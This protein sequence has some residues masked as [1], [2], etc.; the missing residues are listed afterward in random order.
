MLQNY[1]IARQVSLQ[2][3]YR[4]PR[5][6]E[7]A[8]KRGFTSFQLGQLAKDEVQRGSRVRSPQITALSVS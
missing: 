3:T 8:R 4:V 2:N 7:A 6:R 1:D 5:K